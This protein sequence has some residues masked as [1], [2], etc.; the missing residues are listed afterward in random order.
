MNRKVQRGAAQFAAP[1]EIIPEDFT[2][3]QDPQPGFHDS[4]L[5]G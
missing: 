2:K 3:N 5:A 1:A 4:T